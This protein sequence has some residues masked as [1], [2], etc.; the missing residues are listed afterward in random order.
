MHGGGQQDGMRAGTVPVHLVVGMAAAMAEA[1]ASRAS[2]MEHWTR[3]ESIVEQG[4]VTSCGAVRNGSVGSRVP[5][6]LSLT[7]KGVES[8]LL[9]GLL[10][11]RHGICVGTGAACSRSSPSHVLEAMGIGSGGMSGTIRV[12]FG[13]FTAENDAWRLVGVMGSVLREAAEDRELI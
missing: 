7:F 11:E 1:R 3:L 4:L 10:D 12:S 2:S 13:R 6:I 8:A 9:A 5:S